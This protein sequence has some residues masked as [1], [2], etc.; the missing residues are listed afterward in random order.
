MPFVGRGWWLASVGWGLL[1]SHRAE[2]SV[3]FARLAGGSV[4][5]IKGG[6]WGWLD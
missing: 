6:S 1:R 5:V 2:L 3:R 4:I